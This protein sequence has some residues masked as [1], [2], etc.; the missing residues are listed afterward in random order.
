[1]KKADVGPRTCVT[2]VFAYSDDCLGSLL[3]KYG[4]ATARVVA[5]CVC[6][7]LASRIRG[8]RHVNWGEGEAGS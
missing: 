5:I 8:V 1:M 7:T 2:A 4:E 6:A 3:A